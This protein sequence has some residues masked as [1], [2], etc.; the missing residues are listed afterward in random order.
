MR[1]R[2]D[3]GEEVQTM[4]DEPP[5]LPAFILILWCL[6]DLLSPQLPGRAAAMLRQ[7]AAAAAVE[8]L[9]RH[10]HQQLHCFTVSQVA[11]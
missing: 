6:T 3:G 9:S 8:R 2:L 11:S 5:E 1:K 4:M 10:L 7:P